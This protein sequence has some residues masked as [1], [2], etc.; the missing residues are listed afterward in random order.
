M[1]VDLTNPIF[2][3]EEA[4]RKHFE[5]LR[6]PNGRIC[7]HCGYYKGREV[8]AVVA[9]QGEHESFIEVGVRAPDGAL[10]LLICQLV[11]LTTVS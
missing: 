4:A 1:S 9:E 3:N 5:A 10:S 6:W 11:R 8:R 2:S 7:P